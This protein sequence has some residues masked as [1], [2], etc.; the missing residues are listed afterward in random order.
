MNGRPEDAL[1][2]RYER[3]ASS[4]ELKILDHGISRRDVAKLHSK[5]ADEFKG[6][7]AHATAE[8]F[9]ASAL[10]P[11]DVVAMPGE[12]IRGTGTRHEMWALSG[13]RHRGR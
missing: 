4:L 7:E 10:S 12:V 13:M 8:I 3:N 1:L 2:C 5:T 11:E 9:H 6:S